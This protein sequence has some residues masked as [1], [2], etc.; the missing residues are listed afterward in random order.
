MVKNFAVVD[1]PEAAIFVGHRLMAAGR[2]DNA[3]STLA[4][5]GWRSLIMTIVIGAT[6]T[7]GVGHP[8]QDGGRIGG[9]LPTNKSGY[10]AHG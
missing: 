4:E 2:I 9:D 1:N 3:Q 10:T 6:M 8:P 7:K 5:E